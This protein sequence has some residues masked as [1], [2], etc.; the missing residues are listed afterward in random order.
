[1]KE[2]LYGS[3]RL[4]LPLITCVIPFRKLTG[5]LL[6]PGYHVSYQSP[7]NYSNLRLREGIYISL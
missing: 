6:D 5:W 1:M 3:E 7:I 4:K 2:H